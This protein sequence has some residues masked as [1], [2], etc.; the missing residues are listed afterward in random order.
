MIHQ[1]GS[2][3]IIVVNTTSCEDC[4]GALPLPAMEFDRQLLQQL[5]QLCRIDISEAEEEK[6][7]KD[8]KRIVEHVDS[9]QTLDTEGVPPCSHV[10]E[11][12]ANVLR[13][14][15]VGE[16]LPRERF[17]ANAPDHIGGLIRVPAVIQKG[18]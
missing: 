13:D 5:K 8:L 1:F 16:T 17:L 7:L 4:G 11:G 14:D 10:I 15:L 6:L 9:L 2:Y 12:Q 18:G 3:Q